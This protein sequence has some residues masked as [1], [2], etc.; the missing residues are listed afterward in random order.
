MVTV[1]IGLMV[2]AIIGGSQDDPTEAPVEAPAPEPLSLRIFHM[3]DH[4]SKLLDN[5]GEVPTAG[6][7]DFPGNL[8]AIGDEIEFLYGGFSRIKTLLDASTMDTGS[9]ILKLHAGDALVGSIFFSLFEGDSDAEVMNDICFDVFA[10]GNHEFDNGD[11]PLAEFVRS[12]KDTEGCDST[13]VVSANLQ[14]GESSPL[15]L[16]QESGDI[17]TH[18]IKEYPNGEKVGIIGITI[19]EK[20]MISSRPGKPPA[21]PKQRLSLAVDDKPKLTLNIP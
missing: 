5:E 13:T 9:E 2:G 17:A 16:L 20:T 11:A 4:H 6:M 1:G 7:E 18:V 10:L 19:S 3:N 8:T 21:W 15:L 14:A 12:L